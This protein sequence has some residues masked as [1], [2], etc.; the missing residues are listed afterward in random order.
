MMPNLCTPSPFHVKM[1][2]LYHLCWSIH[3]AKTLVDADVQEWRQSKV[4]A[5]RKK[6]TSVFDFWL[7]ADENIDFV[8]QYRANNRLFWDASVDFSCKIYLPINTQ[9][10]KI[11][12]WHI[13]LSCLWIFKRKG[14]DKV[15]DWQ[16]ST[17]V[18][19]PKLEHSIH[20]N[21]HPGCLT[22]SF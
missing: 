16:C 8:T 2:I 21:T 12:I 1:C 18:A 7:T 4:K 14:Q 5:D 19:S 10:Q 17:A 3:C 22:E 9:V 6:T 15:F 20:S 11:I 13:F